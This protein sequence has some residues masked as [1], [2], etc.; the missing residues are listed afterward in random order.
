MP[1]IPTRPT[2]SLKT[3]PKDTLAWS[4]SHGNNESTHHFDLPSLGL[5][6][7]RLCRSVYW[8]DEWFPYS[9]I[10]HIL[11]LLPAMLRGDH[12]STYKRRVYNG[13]MDGHP[14]AHAHPR[15]NS[16]PHPTDMNATHHPW[17]HAYRPPSYVRAL[18]GLSHTTGTR[19]FLHSILQAPSLASH[20]DPRIP[21]LLQY[22]SPWFFFSATGF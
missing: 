1:S 4:S 10:F 13:P 19:S 8:G 2:I 6:G 16:Q 21:S 12:R 5:A 9:G 20:P 17:R 3:A 22:L 7:R 18:G 14:P 15:V 11:R